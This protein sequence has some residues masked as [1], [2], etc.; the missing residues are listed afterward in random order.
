MAGRRLALNYSIKALIVL[1]LPDSQ[2]RQ[3]RCNNLSY[4]RGRVTGGGITP[5]VG[6]PEILMVLVHCL[7]LV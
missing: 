2:R 6:M 5:G 3:G 1:L 4:V 7:L